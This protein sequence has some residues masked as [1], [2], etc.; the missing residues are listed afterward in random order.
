[1]G[2]P[3]LEDLGCDIMKVQKLALYNLPYGRYTRRG[4]DQR[5]IKWLNSVLEAFC[6][7][8]HLTIVDQHHQI[9]DGA[10][11]VAMEG[12]FDVEEAAALYLEADTYDQELEDYLAERQNEH[13]SRVEISA[14]I[15]MAEL[16]RYS[17][18][19]TRY[20]MPVIERLTFTTRPRK[21]EYS[22][23]KKTFDLKKD[24][25]RPLIEVKSSNREPM[26]VVVRETTTVGDLV[27]YFRLDRSIPE[28]VELLGV[29]EN[30]ESL[31]IASN[32]NNERLKDAT[33]VEVKFK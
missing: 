9:E 32:V 11:I 4:E 15:N 22:M 7:V 27:K 19:G 21:E 1:M 14:P 17:W 8:K 5:Y 6:N 20:D 12:V 30:G 28:T 16:E 25:T 31:D 13:R 3:L 33:A 10:D 18:R 24:I 2:K 26:K 29:F 23:A